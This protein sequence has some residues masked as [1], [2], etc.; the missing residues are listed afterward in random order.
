MEHLTRINWQVMYIL[1]KIILKN[2][3]C[4]TELYIEIPII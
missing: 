2:I 4:E 3:F 1:H